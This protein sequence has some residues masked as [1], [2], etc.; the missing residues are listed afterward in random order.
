LR[1]VRAV[2]DFFGIDVGTQLAPLIATD[3]PPRLVTRRLEVQ[4]TEFDGMAVWTLLPPSPSGKVVIALHGGAY[5]VQPTVMHWSDYALMSRQTEATIVVPIYPLAP[6]STAHEV[7]PRIADLITAQIERHAPRTVSVYGDSAGGGLALAASQVL[8]R[9][10]SATPARMVLISPWLDVSMT[11]PAIQG[12]DD[13]ALD[14]ESMQRSGRLW[15][16]DL[17]PTDPLVSP[18]YGTLTGVPPTAVYSG[19][20]DLLNPDV[21]RLQEIASRTPG[22]EFTFVIRAGEMHDWAMGGLPEARA[23][24]GRIYQ[25][26]LDTD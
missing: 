21:L 15:A 16:G 1:I 18:V 24:R 25:Q 8:V 10:R 6:Y 17:E 14:C 9:R 5:V 23:V 20:L 26:L 22:A 19:T 11:N 13:P 4:R 7:V 3:K 2:T 12:V